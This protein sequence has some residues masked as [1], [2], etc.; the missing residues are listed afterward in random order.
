LARQGFL[1]YVFEESLSNRYFMWLRLKVEDIVYM[2]GIVRM[3][4]DR[5]FLGLYLTSPNT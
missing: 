4:T 1:L 3:H 2:V 5:G